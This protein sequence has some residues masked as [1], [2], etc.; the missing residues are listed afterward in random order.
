MDPEELRAAALRGLDGKEHVVQMGFYQCHTYKRLS[1]DKVLE[2]ATYN[3][4]K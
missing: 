4:E 2:A 3:Q 1:G